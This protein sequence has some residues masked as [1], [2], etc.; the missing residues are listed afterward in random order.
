MWSKVPINQKAFD[1]AF[2]GNLI[3]DNPLGKSKTQITLIPYMSGIKTSDFNSNINYDS[4]SFGGDAKVTIGNGM[5][6]DLTFNP[7]FSQVEVDDQIINITRFE[8]NLPEKRQFF[9]QNSDLFSSF[10]DSRDSRT[11]F[12]RRIGVARDCLLYTSPSPR[13]S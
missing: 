5:N 11:F 3:F 7:D 4:F 12:S 1:L 8:I 10:G 13:D 2:F 9:I 6:L